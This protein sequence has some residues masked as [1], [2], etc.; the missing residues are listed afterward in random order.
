MTDVSALEN[1]ELYAAA[2]H[3][4]NDAQQLR[5]KARQLA[6]DSKR[7]REHSQKLRRDLVSGTRQFNNL[8]EWH[9]PLW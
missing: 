2:L 6:Q 4:K 7:L 1:A 9:G 3:L 5:A 8:P